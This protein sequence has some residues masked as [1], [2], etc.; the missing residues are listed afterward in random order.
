MLFVLIFFSMFSLFL[1]DILAIC[2]PNE[3]MRLELG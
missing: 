1:S 3:L 2:V